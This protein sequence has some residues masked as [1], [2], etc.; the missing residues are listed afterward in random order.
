MTVNVG[1][2]CL[3]KA[4]DH[5]LFIFDMSVTTTCTSKPITFPETNLKVVQ[6]VC[7]GLCCH[8]NP[9][10]LNTIIRQ[11]Q[12]KRGIQPEHKL[13]IIIP[14]SWM[15]LLSITLSW[16]YGAA[17]FSHVKFQTSKAADLRNGHG[18][19]SAAGLSGNPFRCCNCYSKW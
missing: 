13:C 9:E 17:T 7:A 8:P 14:S 10:Y 6:T 3:R 15:F 18:G 12:P 1:L 11:Y 4:M 5:F 2:S 16:R 19:I